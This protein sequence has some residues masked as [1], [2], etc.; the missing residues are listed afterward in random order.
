MYS[1][2]ILCFHIQKQIQSHKLNVLLLFLSLPL[3]FFII[4]DNINPANLGASGS[5]LQRPGKI[6][7]VPVLG[8]DPRVQIH[9]RTTGGDCY[10]Y[11]FLFKKMYY[12]I[13]P[14]SQIIHT[15]KTEDCFCKLII[16][17][18][19]SD[20]DTSDHNV[21]LHFQLRDL[22]GRNLSKF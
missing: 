10:M 20:L 15:W 9:E 4:M 6:C 2:F 19:I 11:I 17:I 5:P 12:K 8:F 7:F 21:L 18:D 1:D 16:F 13:T 14:E 3:H 22:C